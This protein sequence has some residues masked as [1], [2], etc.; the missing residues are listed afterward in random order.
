[1][2]PSG[3]RRYR[4]DVAGRWDPERATDLRARRA[5]Y[6]RR[7]RSIR[8]GAVEPGSRRHLLQVVWRTVSDLRRPGRALLVIC[9]VGAVAI[10]ANGLGATPAH[11]AE[12]AVLAVPAILL[13]VIIGQFVQQTVTGRRRA[14]ERALSTTSPRRSPRR[15][16]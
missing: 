5:L 12:S 14:A 7:A 9:A 11:M 4:R 2:A 1:M 13:V 10:A 3:A 16:T 15:P 8:Y 6:E